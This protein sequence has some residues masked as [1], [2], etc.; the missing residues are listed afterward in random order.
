MDR[1]D[2]DPTSPAARGTRRFLLTPWPAVLL[3]VLCYLNTVPNDFT[4]DDRPLVLDNPR[5]HTLT[6]LRALWLSDWWRP[7]A[8]VTE[9]N[10]YRDRLYRPLTLFTFALDFA[11]HGLRTPWYHVTNIALHA[12]VC[13]LVWRVARRLLDDAA[14]ASIAAL[15]FAV[16]P[17]HAEAVA[18]IVG[19]AEVLAALFLLLGI[20]ALRPAAG[21]PG[22]P[23]AVAAGLA[24]LAALLSKET[25]ICYP[26]IAVLVLWTAPAGPRGTW[27]RW[28]MLA[29][30]LLVPLLIYLPIRYVA[31]EGKLFRAQPVDVLLNPLVIARTAERVVAPL[32]IL[33]RYVIL[34]AAPNRLS[35]DYGLAIV[36]PVQGFTA[37]TAL[38]GLAALGLG[39]GLWGFARR[40]P[41]WRSVALLCAMILASYA[42]IS[43]TVLLI[44]V[45]LAERLM[46]WPSV[47]VL[48]LVAVGSAEFWRRYCGPGR[49]LEPRRR[50]LGLLAVLLVVALG[51]RTVVRNADWADNVTLFG[52]DV[53][54]YPQGAHL[55]VCYASALVRAAQQTT[56]REERQP[57]L[58]AALRHLDAA[59]RIDPSFVHVITLTGQVRAQLGDIDGARLYLESAL[60]LQPSD[61]DAR[62]SLARL[63]NSGGE[64]ERRLDALRTDA[65]AQPNDVARQLTLGDALLEAGRY[66]EARTQLERAIALAPDNPRVVRELAKALLFPEQ[67][68]RTVT[69]FERAIALDPNDWESHA[70]LATLL[71]HSDAAAALSHARRAFALRPD[72]IRTHVN[73]AEAL[74]LNGQTPKA[75]EL[76]RRLEPQLDEHDPLRAVIQ[77]RIARLQLEQR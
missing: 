2:T 40:G 61:R 43:N 63:Q 7:G 36:D 76:Y 14:L 22:W 15:L 51:L 4:Y 23:R 12:L 70:N 50:L 26:A 13:G 18:S 68:K 25:A 35:C 33:G 19:R 16:H 47:P 46:Y 54:T 42:L 39:L 53:A 20:L 69:L 10:T 77:A 75:L 31:L 44:G 9:P 17:I 55:N 37:E 27:R 72:D 38:G 3:A 67:D 45:P 74:A 60:R 59:L 49:V 57:L 32:T 64:L 34:L 24:F 29:V 11:V 5:I 28:L 56:V 30:C 71:A 62:Q 6:D 1:A 21:A 73:L 48:L 65:D 58:H 8:D 66:A 52:R 41:A